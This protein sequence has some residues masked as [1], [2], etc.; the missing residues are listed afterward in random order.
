MR[1][2]LFYTL[3][4]AM[5]CG[6]VQAQSEKSYDF[7]EVQ[8]SATTKDGSMTEQFVVSGVMNHVSA[9]GEYAV[10]YDDQGITTNTGGAYLWK[11]SSPETLVPLSETYD[12]VSACD[13]SNDGIVVGSFEL[14]PN[15]DTKGVSFPGWKHVDDA[16]W[17]PLPMPDQY[18]LRFAK[19]YDFAEE[20]RAITPDGATI[21]GNLHFRIGDK[22]VLGS[23]TDE[24]IVPITVWTK[25]GDGYALVKCYTDLGKAGNNF[26]YDA[27]SGQFV[28]TGK[29]V[30][31]KNF[32]VRDISNDGKT[33]VGVNVSWRGGFNPAFMRDGKLYQ[34]FSCG[35]EGE[36]DEEAN[37][38]GGTILTIDANGNMYGYYTDA[39]D[40]TRFF[41]FTAEN[42]LE[43]IDN[44]VVCA[45]KNGNRFA[46]Y[47]KGLYPVCDCSEDGKVIV[48]A[49]VGDLGF[50]QYNYPALVVADDASGVEN[51]QT[52]E[53]GGKAGVTLD[54][55]GNTIRINGNWLSAN[56]YSASGVMV[57]GGNS[58]SSFNIGRFPAGTYIVKVATFAG[59][60]S[61]KV[62]K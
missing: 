8:F 33:V 16:A 6:T 49:G 57:A 31:Y 60:Q 30:A 21:A 44:N 61:F 50:G 12:R 53:A 52:G 32:L 34:I 23:I 41:V 5:A 29:D 28:D 17:T 36:P 25:S 1:K 45:D 27:G 54:F 13:V 26:V 42:K 46:A 19:S 35:E 38:N 24:T 2:T 3:A 14:R 7:Q 40:Q 48:G 11:R 15:S 59:V 62:A 55:D 4:M 22:E 39:A 20:A 9:N 56:V 51:V 43:Y 37:F 58:G 47:D 10:G 18:S